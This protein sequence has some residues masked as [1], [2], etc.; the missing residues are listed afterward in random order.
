MD[1]VLVGLL[2]WIPRIR[3]PHWEDS[4][5]QE[6][7]P[8]CSAAEPLDMHP[9]VGFA[10]LCQGAPHR[11]PA[12]LG[13]DICC[14]LFATLARQSGRVVPISAAP[15]RCLHRRH[16]GPGDRTTERRSHYSSSTSLSVGLQICRPERARTSRA[17]LL[18]RGR[19]RPVATQHRL[20]FRL[21][22]PLP[23]IEE[24]GTTSAC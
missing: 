11:R 6:L 9:R 16:G 10:G 1:A 23:H 22:Q 7:P 15:A 4:S 17:P 13:A 24:R 18:P 12:V 19:R 3:P 2:I 8:G 14:P 21:S 5:S 20:A